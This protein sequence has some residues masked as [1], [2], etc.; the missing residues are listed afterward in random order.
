MQTDSLI[1]IGIVDDHKIFRDGIR[2]ALKEKQ[3]LKVMW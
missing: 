3:N 1:N 2:M